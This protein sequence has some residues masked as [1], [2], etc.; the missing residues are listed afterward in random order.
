MP[1]KEKIKGDFIIKSLSAKLWKL[2]NKLKEIVNRMIRL[3]VW[4]IELKNYKSKIKP[5][6]IWF[7]SI[8]KWIDCINQ[9][10][11]NSTA[12]FGI[13]DSLDPINTPK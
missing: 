12:R 7:G 13:V 11:P 5:I 8:F 1:K 6:I 10:E 3:G 4:V 2:W 9:S